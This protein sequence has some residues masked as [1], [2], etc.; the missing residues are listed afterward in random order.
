LP[1]LVGDEQQLSW[2]VSN[3]VNNA[4][5]YT[6]AGGRVTITARGE[7]DALLIQVNDTGRGIAPEHIGN[8]F[9]KF[10][11]VKHSLD[12][13]PGSVGLGLA[14]AKEVVEMYG[15]SIWVESEL[16]KGSTF[17]FRLPL[18]QGQPV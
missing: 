6:E 16:D 11:Q 18:R 15:G 17:S 9:D 12:A 13:T 10:V 3:L 2:V 7:Q 1:T 8:I 4:L 14:I 5:R